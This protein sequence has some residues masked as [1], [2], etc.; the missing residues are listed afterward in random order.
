MNQEMIT[1]GYPVDATDLIVI[2]QLPIIQEQLQ[3]IKPMV[4]EMVAEATKMQATEDGVKAIKAKRAE[5]N[6]IYS[7]FEE[8]RKEVKTAIMSP[9]EQF[10]AVYK[11][12]V[13]DALKSADQIL[14]ERV[15]LI[16]DAV[17]DQK[18]ED[19][20]KYFYEYAA[21][22]GV[23]FVKFSTLR[24]TI[25]LSTSMKKIKE[26]IR[27]FLD[28]VHDDVEAIYSM[29]YSSE[30][31]TEYREHFNLSEA[32]I[33]VTN[34]H[35]AIEEEMKRAEER[36]RA[37]VAKSE[38]ERKVREICDAHVEPVSVPVSTPVQ[39]EEP[40]QVKEY[41]ITFTVYGT[42]EKLKSLKEFLINGGYKYE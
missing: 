29:E 30:I 39:S 3:S 12:C 19:A 37:E 5:L 14:K 7:A 31:M 6:K 1:V 16:E 25:N 42:L 13:A 17:K 36:S 21:S 33:A 38:S 34:R 27:S 9:Y 4:E 23:D 20:E 22:L 2:E 18:R 24:L 26:E 40:T 10:E 15:A 35:K 41:C 28:T 8:R 32:L 11:E